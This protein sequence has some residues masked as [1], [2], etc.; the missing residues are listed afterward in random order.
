MDSR[1]LGPDSSGRPTASVELLVAIEEL[2]ERAGGWVAIKLIGVGVGPGSFTGQRIG[3]ST[4]RALAQGRGLPLAGVSSTEAMARGAAPTGGE[5]IGVIDARRGEIFAERLDG[6][7]RGAGPILSAPDQLAGIL[8]A[9]AGT[10]A[11]GGGAVRFRQALEAGGLVV[12]ADADPVHT[13]DAA[14]I[15][16]LAQ[17]AGGGDPNAV[18]PAYLRRPDADKWKQ[19]SH[20]D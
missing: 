10:V 16:G 4:A 2:V 17:T 13:L 20:G 9:P 15:C 1:T 14:H 6:S 8:D 19:P 18:L 11:V 3:I 12:P 7:G 5:A